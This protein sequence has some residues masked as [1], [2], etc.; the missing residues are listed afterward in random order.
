MTQKYKKNNSPQFKTAF[1]PI[2]PMIHNPIYPIPP[3]FHNPIYRVSPMFYNPIYPISP[4]FHNPIFPVSPMFFGL[5][6]GQHVWRF[7]KYGR[8]GDEVAHTG[9]V[10]NISC[11]RG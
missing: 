2:S 10:E 5:G 6:M 4:M 11:F 8:P 1:F 9:Y 3:M 7:K